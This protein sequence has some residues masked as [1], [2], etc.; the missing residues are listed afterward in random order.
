MAAW[1]CT[2]LQAQHQGRT[3][4]S[5]H[6]PRP[7]LCALPGRR[8]VLQE[9]APLHGDLPSRAAL[10]RFVRLFFDPALL[11]HDPQIARERRGIEMHPL[12]EIDPAHRTSFG[13]GH[14]QTQLA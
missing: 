4:A 12:A 5:E 10:V 1:S 6:L 9:L 2:L 3:F 7:R 8:D 11:E 14:K 13:Y